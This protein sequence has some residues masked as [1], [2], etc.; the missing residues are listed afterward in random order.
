LVNDLQLRFGVEALH[1]RR[2]GRLS[3]FVDLDSLHLGIA[4]RMKG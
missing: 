2:P 4:S 1:M 3:F